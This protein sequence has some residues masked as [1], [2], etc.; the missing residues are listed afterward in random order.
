MAHR[1]EHACTWNT[2][3]SRK[4][5][6]NAGQINGRGIDKLRGPGGLVSVRFPRRNGWDDEKATM[7][8]RTWCLEEGGSFVPMKD[9]DEVT[10]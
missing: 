3:P 4:R 7:Q 5:E 1:H 6:N 2:G 8:A 9:R 10:R